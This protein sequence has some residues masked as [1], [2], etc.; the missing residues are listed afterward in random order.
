M[1]RAAKSENPRLYDLWM[2]RTATVAILIVAAVAFTTACGPK[3]LASGEWTLSMLDGSPP[4]TGTEI[5]LELRDTSFS[6]FDGCNKL[7]GPSGQTE[8]FA[9]PDG[10]FGIS[11]P[12]ERT[13][14]GCDTPP[15]VMEQAERYARA[16]MS[17]IRYEIVG[18]R[19][20]IADLEGVV[21]FVFL[22]KE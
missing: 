10:A 7:G 5:S 6:S 9:K 13:D 8:L 19:L 4:I 14:I 18:G 17:G 22:K 16:L 2:W 20:E 3:S 15:G 12:V 11:N 21:R 1:D